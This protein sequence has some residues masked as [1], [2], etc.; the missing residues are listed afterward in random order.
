MSAQHEKVLVQWF[1]EHPEFYQK[2]RYRYADKLYMEKQLGIIAAQL[3]LKS[4]DENVT[5][6]GSSPCFYTLTR[7]E[8]VG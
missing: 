1:S 4:N 3:L 5:T 7:G 8:F 2:N 6:L